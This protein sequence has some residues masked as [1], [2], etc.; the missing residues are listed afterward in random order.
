MSSWLPEVG[1]TDGETAD[2][3]AFLREYHG[4]DAA[5]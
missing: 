2:L 3:Y 5:R 4:F 1:F